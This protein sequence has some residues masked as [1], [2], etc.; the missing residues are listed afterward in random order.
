M[1]LW[2]IH[3]KP[4]A[5][6]LLS[7]WVTRIAMANRMSASDFYRLSL[8]GKRITFTEIDRNYH[9]EMMQVLAEG[10]GVPIE[11]VWDASLVSDEGYVF[12][13]RQYGTTEWV[14]PTVNVDGHISKGLAYCPL[15]LKADPEPY[16]RKSWRYAFNSVCPIHRAFLR[17]GC[18]ECCSPHFYFG[19]A[20]QPI[21]DDPIKTCMRCGADISDTQDNTHHTV[22]IEETLHIQKRLNRGITTD[23]FDIPGYGSIRALPY[24]RML[25]ALMRSLG[26]LT[27]ANWVAHHYRESLPHGIDA[28]VL[29]RNYGLLIEQRSME[30][31]ATLLCLATALIAEW[32]NRLLHFMGKN[33]ITFHRLLSNR[34]IPFW[35]TETASEYCFA[36]G[37]AFSKAEVENARQL[38]R[39]KLGRR[40]TLSELKSFMADG[41]PRHMA[42]VSREKRQDVELSSRHFKLEAPEQGK[43]RRLGN[44]QAQ[45]SKLINAPAEQLAKIA[46]LR[47]P[48]KQ[49]ENSVPIQSDLFL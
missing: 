19:V 6:E 42:K 25:H 40:E 45:A 26:T 34:R 8:P 29:D 27:M 38:L 7:S 17:Q 15:C 33:E 31:I 16:Y 24:L 49:S 13:Y 5:D 10:A 22:I 3:P 37:S 43:T 2:P 44:H 30:E 28:N 48:K 9:P 4:H 23:S 14:L 12:L 11:H 20:G 36:E 39:A 46:I 41:V 35:I 47:Q 21:G 32:P 1:Q 18:P